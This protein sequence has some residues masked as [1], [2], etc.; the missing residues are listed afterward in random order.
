LAR[1]RPPALSRTPRQPR[2]K[3]DGDG[4]EISLKRLRSLYHVD[5]KLQSVRPESPT[6][7]RFVS[8]GKALH[9]PRP[10]ARLPP[11]CQRA[12]GGSATTLHRSTKFDAPG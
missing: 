11:P 8:R 12:K 2:P 3:S 4:S 9:D 10:L 7:A 1:G 6:P 5:S